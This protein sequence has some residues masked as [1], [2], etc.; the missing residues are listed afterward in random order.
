MFLMLFRP[1]GGNRQYTRGEGGN[2]E[3]NIASVGLG[4]GFLKGDSL[5]AVVAGTG[6]WV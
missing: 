4:G 5:F 3:H 1:D 2:G 6:T